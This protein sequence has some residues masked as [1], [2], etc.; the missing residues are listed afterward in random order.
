MNV[1]SIFTITAPTA[2]LFILIQ[3]SLIADMND[4]GQWP[5][6]TPDELEVKQKATHQVI[7]H[8]LQDFYDLKLNFYKLVVDLKWQVQNLSKRV[9]KLELSNIFYKNTIA[10]HMTL[11]SYPIESRR[12]LDP[13]YYPNK[14][15]EEEECPF[16]S[17]PPPPRS[18]P[19]SRAPS[20][21]P[22]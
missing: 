5:S 3:T 18:R 22:L 1:G 9:E 11:T 13:D 19:M 12:A 20:L 2:Q 15:V 8:F 16:P 6:L 21:S 17:L 7:S 14:Q 10:H 4:S